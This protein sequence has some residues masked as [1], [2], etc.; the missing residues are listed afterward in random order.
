MKKILLTL[1]VLILLFLGLFFLWPSPVDSAAW[2]PPEAPGLEGPAKPNEAL[3]DADV[4]AK[5]EIEG[6][7]DTEVD[8]EGNV[9][10]GLQDG[11][12]IRVTPEGEVETFADTG[13]RPLGMEFDD[14]GN[15][16]VADA[17]KGLLSVAPDGTVEVLTTGSEG[18]PFAFTDDLAI[19]SDGRIYFSDA[20]SR[21]HQPDYRLDMLES[22][23]HGRLLRYDP[24]TGETE[25]LMGDLHFA[26]GVALTEDERSVLVNETW[27]YRIQQYWLEGDK[28][29]TSEIFA[30]NLP[31]FPD[32]LS[33]DHNGIIWVALPTRRN[34]QMDAFHPSPWLKE[35]VAK[36]PEFLQPSPESYGLVL[37]FDQQGKMLGSLHDPTGERVQML[38]S[39]KARDGALYFGS[40]YN[41]RIGRLDYDRAMKALREQPDE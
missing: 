19:A 23:P 30:R 35:Q 28:A 38:T 17:W 20:S 2:E 13:G 34:P 22:R 36:L 33:A 26:N 31:G 5:G 15:L 3:Q 8:G 11:R 6:P 18:T 10:G 32:N 27:R 39:V 4:L 24:E 14:D 7:E 29:G 37:A 16:I 1:L 41:D 9:Y 12:I 40:L 25:T 21:F